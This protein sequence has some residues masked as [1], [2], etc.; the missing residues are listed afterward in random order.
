M[1]KLLFILLAFVIACSTPSGEEDSKRPS[2]WKGTWKAEWET[3]PESYPGIEDMEFYMQGRFIFSDDSL[4][5]V[6]YG[7]PGCIF[8]I[9][10]LSHTQS[11]Y[12][13]NDTLFLLNNSAGTGMTYKVASKSQDRIRL[14]LMDDIFVTLSK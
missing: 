4:T 9:D 10:T 1:K 14:Q 8:A 2:D 7:Y 6:V 5:K 3:P 11:W 13:S 12:V